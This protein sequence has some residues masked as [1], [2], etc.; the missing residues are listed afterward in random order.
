MFSPSVPAIAQEQ[1]TEYLRII[2]NLAQTHTH[3]VLKIFM[4]IV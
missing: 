4:K 1:I 2:I 3:K